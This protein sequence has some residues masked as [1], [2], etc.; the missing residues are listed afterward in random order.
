MFN[1]MSLIGLVHESITIYVIWK[2][3]EKIGKI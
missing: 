3:L 2:C 1:I